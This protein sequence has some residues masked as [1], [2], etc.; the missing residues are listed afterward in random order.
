MLNVYKKED[1]TGKWAKVDTY[2]FDWRNTN[3]Q[4]GFSIMA[5][6]AGDGPKQ[7]PDMEA[8]FTN[9]LLKND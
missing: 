4:V 8:V 1:E 6:F 2:E 5:R 7:R 3:L 9:I